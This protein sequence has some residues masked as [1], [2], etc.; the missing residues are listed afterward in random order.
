MGR[1]GYGAQLRGQHGMARE[2][3]GGHALGDGYGKYAPGAG[4]V[5]IQNEPMSYLRLSRALRER[6][7]SADA[8][9][10][11]IKAWRVGVSLEESD[12][13]KRRGAAGLHRHLSCKLLQARESASVAMCHAQ[14]SEPLPANSECI[15]LSPT[16][17]S[18]L[19]DLSPA[20]RVAFQSIP[21]ISQLHAHGHSRPP[22]D[23]HPYSAASLFTSSAVHI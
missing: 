21:C 9:G 15:L 23:R 22:F 17:S 19:C 16:C 10:L 2:R 5:L 12:A 4:L 11:R 3:K 7:Q 13:G 14:P 8:A 6:A 20:C 18:M 1:G